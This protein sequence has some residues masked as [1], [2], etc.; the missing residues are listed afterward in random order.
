[1]TTD[2]RPEQTWEVNSYLLTNSHKTESGNSK[3][4]DKHLHKVNE[5]SY[6]LKLQLFSSTQKSSSKFSISLLSPTSPH[7]QIKT[8]PDHMNTSPSQHP[9][10]NL[11]THNPSQI[12]YTGSKPETT[13]HLSSRRPTCQSNHTL[14]FCFGILLAASG[15]LSP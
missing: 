9:L 11:K 1:M 14:R 7:F 12:M 2:N 8:F 4:I 13:S 3:H 6:L 5:Q 10:P 15:L